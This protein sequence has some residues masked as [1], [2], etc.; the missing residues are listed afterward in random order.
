M[1]AK[2]GTVEERLWR[3]VTKT[4]FL[5]S[6][7]L[8]HGFTNSDGYGVMRDGNKLLLVHRVSWSI[9]Y[10]FTPLDK[11]TLVCH[12]CDVRNC[13]R[14]SHLFTG[15]QADNMRDATE[16]A[17]R[18]FGRRN[19]N[20]VFYSRDIRDIRAAF[21]GGKSIAQLARDYRVAYNS[22]WQIVRMKTWR[23]VKPHAGTS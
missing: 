2:R 7:W 14:P 9:A 3:H 18:A 1:G 12:A 11:D 15:S 17:R 5:R 23:Q 8:W 6:C 4:K 22:M 10:P 16:K 21:A 13:V 20:A 19:H